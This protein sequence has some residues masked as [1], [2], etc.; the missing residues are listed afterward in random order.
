[1]IPWWW[2]PVGVFAGAFLGVFVA[3]LLA[4]AKDEEDRL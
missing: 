2:L 3:A 4:A 1:M